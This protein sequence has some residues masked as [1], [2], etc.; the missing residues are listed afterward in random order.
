MATG[1]FIDVESFRIK[2]ETNRQKKIVFGERP[3][4]ISAQSLKAKSQ[5]VDKEEDDFG[6]TQQ[7]LQTVNMSQADQ[8]TNKV[9]SRKSPLYIMNQENMSLGVF[10]VIMGGLVVPNVM[11][12]LFF[13][14]FGYQ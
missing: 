14:A 5:P 8:T 11:L 7:S 10:K 9:E 1:Q 12:N 2:K 3:T 4:N 6:K 13:I